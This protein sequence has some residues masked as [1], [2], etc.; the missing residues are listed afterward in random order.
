MPKISIVSSYF[1]RKNELWR[2][3]KVMDKSSFKD[4][5]Y[6]I[7][8]DGSDYRQRIEDLAEEFKFVKLKRIEPADKH[9]INPCIPFNM[10][11][12]M[13]EG[14]IIILQSPE[15]MHMGDVLNFVANNSK[16]NQ[17]LVF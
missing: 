17:Y 7:V 6:V 9:H 15:C 1:N 12:A 11:I 10:G 5:E 14:D 2:T 16:D 8:D 3:L 13:A 4:F